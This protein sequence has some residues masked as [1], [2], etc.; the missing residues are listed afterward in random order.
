GGVIG[1]TRVINAKPDGYTMLLGTVGTHAYN[2]WIYKK[3]R[4]DA[5]GDFTPVTLFSEQPMVLEVRK[6]LPANTFADFI[7]LVKKDG[8]KMQYGSAGAGTTTHLACA[9]L[10][11]RLGANVTHVPYRGSA[12]A[13]NDLIGGQIDYVCGN[14]GAAIALI[15]GKQVKA[16]A[17]LS[18]ERSALMPDL[19][20]PHEMGIAD[21]DVTTWTAFFL[22]KGASQEIVAK[23]VEVTQAAMETPAIRTRMHEIGVTGVTKDRQTP[24]YLAKYVSEEIARWEGPIKAAGLQVD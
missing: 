2:Q 20:T 3:R 23:L 19:P 14:I 11:A 7:T 6:D 21:Y 24:E 13:T 4:Y 15:K 1:A 22:P 12:P 17:M 16:L 10:N 5:V 9:L 8:G 18:K